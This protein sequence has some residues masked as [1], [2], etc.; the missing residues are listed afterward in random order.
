MYGLPLKCFLKHSSVWL[1]ATFDIYI[2]DQF[3]NDLIAC[4]KVESTMSKGTSNSCDLMI[5][6]FVYLIIT[7]FRLSTIKGTLLSSWKA[8]TFKKKNWF[9]GINNKKM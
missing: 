9:P 4:T 8:W 6:C 5:C 3:L 2:L 1:V 7:F